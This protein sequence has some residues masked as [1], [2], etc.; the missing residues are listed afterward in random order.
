MADA[1]KLEYNWDTQR[2][3]VWKM[4]QRSGWFRPATWAK[5]AE[6]SHAT[7]VEAECWAEKIVGIDAKKGRIE[8]VYYNE[9]GGR[10]VAW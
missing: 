1:Y 8:T 3:I 4:V 9:D 6:A 2:A 5:L 7:K 10:Y